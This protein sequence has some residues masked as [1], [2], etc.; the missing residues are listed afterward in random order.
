M[1]LIIDFILIAGIVIGSL[2]LFLLIKNDKKELPQ[3]ILIVLFSYILCE[4]IIA[5]F[6]FREIYFLKSFSLIFSSS[7]TWFLGPLFFLYIKSLFSDQDKL[8]KMNLIH[9]I[10]Y[11]IYV[12]SASIIYLVYLQPEI[13][14]ATYAEIFREKCVIEVVLSDSYLVLYL[15]LALRMFY[16]YKKAI[17]LNYSN[18]TEYDF[19][20]IKYMLIGYLFTISID[21]F[22][23]IINTYS[24]YGFYL[25]IITMVIVIIYLGYYGINQSRILLPNFLVMDDSIIEEDSKKIIKY[26][27][28]P[29]SNSDADEL[30][31]KLENVLK[32]DKPYLDEAITLKKLADMVQISD[33]K[34]S[35]FLNQ[36]MNISFYD[37]IN[38]HRVEAVKEKMISEGSEKY[39]LMGL[40]YDCGFSA[41][42]SFIRVF[43]KETGLSPSE[44]K[45]QMLS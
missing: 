38:K 37:I 17:K 14:D 34:L 22:I 36:N 4:L 26:Q 21:I 35:A 45:K 44:Y 9:F 2:I 7:I 12:F 10:P 15:I 43:K 1:D 31:I 29:F 3:Y 42:S 27:Q 8:I 25:T 20:W 33:K 19:T 24:I 40:A 23:S 30:K 16:M 6:F 18:L 32:N 5:Y 13:V 28:S 39:T 41:K 11:F